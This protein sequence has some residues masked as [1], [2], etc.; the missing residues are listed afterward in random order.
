MEN[1]NAYQKKLDTVN[2][3]LKTLRYRKDYLLQELQRL[4]NAR[5]ITSHERQQR[6]LLYGYGAQPYLEQEARREMNIIETL[7]DALE[8]VDEQLL[9]KQRMSSKYENHILKMSEEFQT[10][11]T[12]FSELSQTFIKNISMNKPNC[13]TC[14]ITEECEVE[15]HVADE[16]DT[17]VNYEHATVT[18]VSEISRSD[19]VIRQPILVKGYT[20][21]RNYSVGNYTADNS[22]RRKSA[23]SLT[24]MVSTIKRLVKNQAHNRKTN[25][26]FKED[27]E[28]P[29]VVKHVKRLLKL[30]NLARGRT[31]KKKFNIAFSS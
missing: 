2:G 26:N 1:I 11:N 5:K 30:H 25:R 10:V 23:L 15:T 8:D 29:K 28:Q 24:V 22:K 20:K 6:L 9:E 16:I 14:T 19:I 21:S 3:Q 27:P 12:K 7:C 4:Q 31:K 13:Y 18:T 17:T